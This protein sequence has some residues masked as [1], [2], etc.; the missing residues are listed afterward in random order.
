MILRTQAL[1]V[2]ECSIEEFPDF[3]DFLLTGKISEKIPTI[4]TDD[5]V[6]LRCPDTKFESEACQPL[7]IASSITG[8]YRRQAA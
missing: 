2:I 1:R 8:S 4:G 7:K 5:Y 6:I 3:L